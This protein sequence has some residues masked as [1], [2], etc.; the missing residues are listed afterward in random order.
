MTECEGPELHRFPAVWSGCRRQMNRLSERR[1]MYATLK[2]MEPRRSTVD[3][4]VAGL[5]G[6]A[7]IL[8]FQTELLTTSL[9]VADRFLPAAVFHAL[10][11]FGIAVFMFVLGEPRRNSRQYLTAVLGRAPSLREIW[12][13]YRAFTT[14][15]LL[16]VRAA[17]GRVHRC[18]AMAGCEEFAALMAS[19]RP[20]LLGTFNLGNSDLL[21]F[22]LGQFQRHVFMVRYR[23]GDPHFLRQ[24]ADR[25]Q[26]WVTFVWVNEREN[27][28]FSLKDVLEKGGSIAMKCDG[29]GDSAKL[30]AFEFL[31][32]RRWFPFTIYH[33][34]VMFRRPVTFCM[35]VPSGPDESLV[36]GTP[37]F[38]PDGDSR[39][40]NLQRARVHFQIVL[41]KVEALLRE[42]P[43][44]WFNFAPFNP[45]V[46]ATASITV[47]TRSSPPLAPAPDP[48]RI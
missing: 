28:L 40:S 21:G 46:A 18:R 7:R 5:F 38:E 9:R 13:H 27:L 6:G 25:M 24:L 10:T 35:S 36:H 22:V 41:N 30:E 31:G 29:V 48:A 20:A 45:D 33:L 1:K 15:H 39:E 3:N 4:P 2:T 23:L 37:V 44:L 34:A 11:G 8:H 42:N 32:A 12:R 43:Y 47:P 17:A 26:A 14:M 19:N 16:R